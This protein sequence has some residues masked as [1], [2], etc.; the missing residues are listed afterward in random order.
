MDFQLGDD[1]DA[2]RA[3]TAQI[4]TERAGA[5]LLAELDRAGTWLD[6]RTY[7]LLADAGVL[8][9]VLPEAAGGAGLG[10]L[11]MHQVLE[12]VG[13]HTAQVPVWEVV[14]LGGLTLARHGSAQQQEAW[15][16]G[17]A[18]GTRLLTAALVE[19]DGAD[20]RRP[21]TTAVPAADAAD[22]PA[23]GGWRV[24][25]VKTQVPLGAAAH[26][27]LVPASTDDG[28][29]LVLLVDPSGPGVRVE[30]QRSVSG[31]DLARV[32]LAGAHGVPVG[33]PGEVLDDLLR[34]AEAGLAAV[35]L[36]NAAAAL[37]LAADYTSGREQFGQPLATFQAVR[38][39]LADGYIDVEAMRLTSWQAC[40][41]LDDADGA[42]RSPG[43]TAEADRAVAIARFWAADGGHRV[44]STAQHVHGG[45]GID[46]DY[47]LHRHFRLGKHVEMTLGPAGDQLRRLGRR[48]AEERMPV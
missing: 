6:D 2:L 4:L 38:Q 1:I 47:G 16:P 20:R 31:R 43:S 28:T 14:V 10:A 24:D 13:A 37:R 18:D 45:I 11:A 33:A 21:R 39:R 3:L 30:A 22:D 29:T 34:H 19:P 35:Q 46:L 32:T 17:I 26:G 9:A 5:E 36:G 8:A 12:Q 42:D 7:A 44:L 27:L 15:L 25:G 41:A 48:F 23:D 40:S